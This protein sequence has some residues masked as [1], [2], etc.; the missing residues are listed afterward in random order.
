MSTKK[1]LY[2][3][4]A[5]TFTSFTTEAVFHYPEIRYGY[6]RDGTIYKAGICFHGAAAV[7]QRAERCCKVW[8]IED[9]Y[10]TLVEVVDSPWVREIRDDTDE[11]WRDHWEMHHY[12]IYLESCFE[13]IADSWEVISEEPGIW[14]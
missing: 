11:R 5:G 6:E 14:P 10:D 3:I 2:K 12:M 8:H 13:I 9:T 7:R 4:P 1:I